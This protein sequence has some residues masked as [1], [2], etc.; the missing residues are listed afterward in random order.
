MKNPK[1]LLLE[2][3]PA[4]T[5]L[6]D[7][8]LDFLSSNYY[9]GFEMADKYTFLLDLERVKRKRK[10]PTE[11]QIANNN[12]V[13]QNEFSICTNSSIKWNYDNLV[14]F[15]R[16]IVLGTYGIHSNPS[17]YINF[18]MPNLSLEVLDSIL[19]H[20]KRQFYNILNDDHSYSTRY[21]FNT[22]YYFE[23]CN[24]YSFDETFLFGKYKG[25]QLSEVF[26]NDFGYLIWCIEKLE[27]F[28]VDTDVIGRIYL[29]LYEHSN[30]EGIKIFDRILRSKEVY[31]ISPISLKQEIQ[32][33]INDESSPRQ[34]NDDWYLDAMEGDLSNEWNID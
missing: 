22:E 34:N 17:F 21:S 14:V 7:C 8:L 15:E 12:I 23:K 25:I 2:L 10:I 27:K 31:K 5:S 9:S 32:D 26:E 13:I 33:S 6:T 29:K 19:K 18:V 16:E 24:W 4:N 1:A 28:Y 3:F 30:L 20:H 11:H